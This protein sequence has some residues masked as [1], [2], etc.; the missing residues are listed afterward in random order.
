MICILLSRMTP[1]LLRPVDGREGVYTLVGEVYVNGIMYGEFMKDGPK[2]KTIT[3][4]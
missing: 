2:V 4:K 3:L 1:S